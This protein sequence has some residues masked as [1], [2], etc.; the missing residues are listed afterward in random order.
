MAIS[1]L[2]SLGFL[3]LVP[4]IMGWEPLGILG[5][6]V[7][8][9]IAWII[10]GIAKLVETEKAQDAEILGTYVT[11]AR[12]YEPWTERIKHKDEETGEVTYEDVEHDEEWEVTVAEGDTWSI[13]EDE[14]Q[15]Y[16]SLFGNEE[17]DEADHYGEA[18]GEIID[19]GFC[20]TT[21]WPGTFATARYKY[22][23]RFYKNP[24]LSAPNVYESEKLDHET[25]EAYHL[26]NYECRGRYGT[27]NGADV[28]CLEDEIR[29]Y[30]CWFREKNIKLNFIILENV[31]STHAT[32][33]Q[34]YW[35]NGKRNTVNAV[36][37]VNSEHKIEWAHVFGWQN[38]ST[39]IKLRNFITGL[40]VLAD[41]TTHFNQVKEI[42]KENY[43]FPDF[44]QY[45]FV[46]S[47]FPLQGTIIALTICLGIFCGLCCRP[48]QYN[49]RA[50][51]YLR[52]RNYSL[53][54]SNFETYL[55]Q[56]PDDVYA[57]NNLG[58]IYWWEKNYEKSE[59]LFSRV[60]D[61][62]YRFNR[63]DA[64]AIYLNR[65]ICYQDMKQHKKAI[66]DFKQAIEENYYNTEP[67]CALYNLYKE[68]NYKK[69][70][71]ALQNQYAG[72][73]LGS[74]KEDCENYSP[75]LTYIYRDVDI[76]KD[77]G[78][79]RLFDWLMKQ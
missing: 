2:F 65:G 12:Y 34:Q 66:A 73:Q 70:I 32:Y 35:Q 49:D 22:V 38:E 50:Q 64:I 7:G 23:E 45:D 4:L 60:I 16:V 72:Y 36:V 48:P 1:F 26:E 31:P 46:Q 68:L 44:S 6:I 67:Y 79:V 75:R 52:Q 5:I 74:L 21:T 25:I 42:L 33:W 17:E 76:I 20:Y 30:N 62:I 39:C 54:K 18:E 9:V 40:T 11:E 58:V 14:Y 61:K 63:Y 41:I 71:R 51:N 55:A 29:D 27:A 10:I 56:V 69:S 37:G 57:L 77:R 59:Q 53:A 13:D 47:K 78:F 8:S 15:E 19:P 28:E 24:T 43:V 3:L